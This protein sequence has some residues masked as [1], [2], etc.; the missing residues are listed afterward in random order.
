M[1]KCKPLNSN[2]LKLIAIVAMTIDHIAWSVFPGFPVEVLPLLMHLVGRTTCPI[3]CYFI[4][5]GFHH[6]KNINKYTARLF[7]FAVIS[8]FAYST[9]LV[10]NISLYSFIPFYYGS[11]LDQT[12]VMWSL[13]WG[14]VLL[15]IYY[16]KK[17]DNIY[18]KLLLMT[19]VCIISFP[20]DWSCVA[21]LCVLSVGI[22]RGDFKKQMLSMV[23][24]VLTYSIVYC[25][26]INFVYGILQMG[27][28][29][30]IPLLKMYNGKR[31]ESPTM[32]KLMKWFFY[33]YYPLHLVA[34][35][36]LV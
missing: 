13:A 35:S 16:S 5:E 14:L 22:N 9:F 12:S 31:G 27:V 1:E 11:L 29:L 7:V 33:A 2:Q 28:V 30:S 24:F 4:A 20:A 26:C 17:A 8:H 3:M 15:R 32:N 6:T 36:V 19:L 21:S 10:E 34:L 23:F 18:V 25:V